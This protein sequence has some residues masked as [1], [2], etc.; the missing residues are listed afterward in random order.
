MTN[1]TPNLPAKVEPSASLSALTA[2]LDEVAPAP[3]IGKLLK[4]TKTGEF[5][6]GQDA[7]VVKDGTIAVA[8]CDLALRGFIRW[9]EGAPAEQKL[10]A[11]S[12]G[13]PLPQREKLGWHDQ[14]LWPK[15]Q[16]GKPRDVWQP[17]IYVPLMFKEDGELC[18]FTTGSVSGVNSTHKLLRHYANHA[19][20][21]PED[22]PLV[23]LTKAH[24][25]PRKDPTIGKVLYPDFVPAGYVDR[26]EFVEAL[27]AVGVPIDMPDHGIA[28]LPKPSDVMDD[29]VPF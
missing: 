18:T 19:R 16:N 2:Y 5:C 17:V 13:K 12:T 22:Y 9:H 25:I 26:K 3:T 15:D 27:E 6:K 4:F 10:V 14:A 29:E 8:A 20:R 28:A 7:E 24:F 1:P 21:H 11:L 23:K